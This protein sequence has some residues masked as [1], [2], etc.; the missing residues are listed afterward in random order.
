MDLGGQIHLGVPEAVVISFGTQVWA[1]PLA[2]P[3]QRLLLC[4]GIPD[5]IP[6]LC[7]LRTVPSPILHSAVTAHTKH[8][9]SS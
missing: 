4:Q 7:C 8:Q 9:V 3:A 6:N 1:V 2:G 5:F